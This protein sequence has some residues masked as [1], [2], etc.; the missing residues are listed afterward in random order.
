MTKKL[1]GILLLLAIAI[2]K[3]LWAKSTED[4]ES[5]NTVMHSIQCSYSIDVNDMAAVIGDADYCFIAEVD[6]G[7]WKF[8]D[9]RGKFFYSD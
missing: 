8:T 5:E 2:G 3:I 1:T 4:G 9:I 7:R 6:S